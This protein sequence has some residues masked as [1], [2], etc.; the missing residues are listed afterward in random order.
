MKHIVLFIFGVA[1]F[2]MNGNAQVFIQNTLYPFN[3]SIYNPA[4]VGMGQGT[5]LTLM[6]RLQW[7][8]IDGAPTL[9]TTSVDTKVDA[10]QGGV[11]GYII[12]D[13]LG[14]LTTTGL[15]GSYA[16]HLPII[17]DKLRLGIGA[18]VGIL[19]KSLNGEFRYD[20]TNGE[21]PIVP[22]GQYS[23]SLIVPSLAVGL[24]LSGLDEEGKEQFYIGISGQ[25]LLEPT[26]DGL[27]F[28]PGVGEDSRVSR[29]FYLT[30]GYRFVLSEDLEL[31]PSF[32]ARTDGASFQADL[33]AFLTLKSLVILGLSH[34]FYNDSFAGSLGVRISDNAFIA[35]S[36][37]YT[38]NGLNQN[39]DISSHEIILSYTFPKVGKRA[40]GRDNTKDKPNSDL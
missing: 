1:L 13:K 9:F 5:N 7:L 2:G 29:T 32:L 38:L 10:I 31:E 12:A 19:Q 24:Y 33:S 25:D 40:S 11:G 39:G 4:A 15:N 21:D 27:T 17:E 36:Y 22:L 16:Y 20:A 8:G 28:T 18:S 6:G 35:Y 34:R 37:D 3:R 30:G 23:N 26:I 14:P